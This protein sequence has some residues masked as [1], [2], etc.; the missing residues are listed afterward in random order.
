MFSFRTT[1]LEQQP[2]LV[3]KSGR[4]GVLCNQVAWNPEKGE[5]LFETLYKNGNLKKVFTPDDVTDAYKSL[6][7]DGCEFFSFNGYD[8]DSLSEQAEQLSD[9]DALVVE[10]QDVGSR[11][12]PVLS[13]LFNLFLTLH[14]NDLDLSVYILDREN[15]AGRSVEGTIIDPQYVSSLG[16]EGIPHRHGLTIG[17]I[18]NLFHSEIG[19]KFHL[20]IVSYL[21]RSATQYMMPWSIP[22]SEDIAGLFTCE[23]YSGQFLWNGTNVSNGQGTT[24]PYEMFGAP[25]MKSLAG[26]NRKQGFASWNDSDNPVFDPG[27]FIRWTKFTPVFDQ[28]SGSGC[29]GFQLLSNPGVQYHALAHQIRLM[30]FVA[31]NCSDFKF[32][33]NLDSIVG[34][35]V[36]LDFL[37]DGGE[38][39]D[40][41]EHIKVEEQKWIRKA[42]RFLLYDNPLWRVKSII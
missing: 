22:P 21:V 13:I 10:L 27:V 24:R 6:G 7:L 36:I 38:W 26:F 35:A 41:K 1:P 4:V 39:S 19:A 11:Y 28:Y 9:I 23:F 18:A 40:V 37:R 12:Y 3:L 34:D 29:F 25:F 16:V 2:D 20:H 32:N 14:H 5:Y 30:R 33:A 15:P 8:A 17:E 31:D 42:K